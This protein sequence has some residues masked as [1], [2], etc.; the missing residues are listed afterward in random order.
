[1]MKN[2]WLLF[3]KEFV[4]AVRDRRTALLVIIFP[5]LFYPFVLGIIYHYTTQDIQTQQSRPSS[6]LYVGRDADP[7]LAGQFLEEENLAPIFY[8]DPSRAQTALQQGKGDLLIFA[9]PKDPSGLSISIKYSQLKTGSEVALART[10]EAIQT[11][12]QGEMKR[13]LSEIGVDYGEITPPLTLNVENTG[14]SDS[15]IGQAMVKR[16][17]PYFIVLAIITASMGLGAEI[18]AGEKEKKT[19]STLLVSR[20]K[21]TEI[22]WGKFLVIAT[23]AAIG[24]LLGVLGLV[25]GLSFFGVE[26]ELHQAFRPLIAGGIL[27]TLIPLVAIMSAIV[28]IV[29][30]FARTQKEANIY[31]TPIY[32]IIIMIGIISMSGG[33]T[34]SGVSYLFPVINSLEVFKELI[35]GELNFFH[36]GLTFGS[37]LFLGGLLLYCS[38]RL[39]QK[40][41]IL[42]RN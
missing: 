27:V 14:S 4:Q 2:I 24:A 37:N 13:K 39:F 17:L 26:L 38:V 7:Q 31:Q 23:V 19:I 15:S 32:M 34:L 40:E 21:R 9:R 3:K 33:F 29:G 11:Y 30:T 6:I 10:K 5:L 28:M 12:L 8:S 25:Y 35:G 20:L 22:V 18:T 36:M 41:T 16:L 42:F 1:M